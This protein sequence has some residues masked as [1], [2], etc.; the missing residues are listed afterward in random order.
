[1]VQA[2]A[3][4]RRGA[5][6]ITRRVGKTFDRNQVVMSRRGEDPESIKVELPTPFSGYGNTSIS[7]P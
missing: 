3:Y 6:L 1:M 2:T 5:V 7:D 4:E